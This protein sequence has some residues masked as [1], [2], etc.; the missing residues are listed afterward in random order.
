M[1]P[2]S[3]RTTQHKFILSIDKKWIDAAFI[4]ELIEK[5]TQ[6]N[7]LK[8]EHITVLNSS[9]SRSELAQRFKASAKPDYITSKYDV[10]EQ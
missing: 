6:K 9:P 5:I 2:I 1:P 4:K 3:I 10:Y 7:L 8:N